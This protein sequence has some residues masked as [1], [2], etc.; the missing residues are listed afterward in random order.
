MEENKGKAESIESTLRLE[1]RLGESQPTKQVYCYCKWMFVSRR[2]RSWERIFPGLVLPPVPGVKG[3]S[4]GMGLYWL[5][6]MGV[7]KLFFFVGIAAPIVI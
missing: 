6:S 5:F 7:P 3:G 1:E 4:G 2:L